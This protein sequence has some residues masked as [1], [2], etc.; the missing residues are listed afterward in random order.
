MLYD[1]WLKWCQIV[2]TALVTSGIAA[3]IFRSASII[4]ILTGLLSAIHLVITT[5]MKNKDYGQIAQLH[6][7][8]AIQ[9]WDI[10]ERLLSLLIDYKDN[11]VSV[12]EAQIKRDEIHNQLL[13]VYEKA[14][15]T[16][17]KAYSKAK[18]ALKDSEELYFSKDEI[19]LLL[20]KLL[21]E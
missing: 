5:Y 15:R 14:P 2:I 4:T 10:R 11:R 21:R 8:T 9:V 6:A 17:A 3:T 20:P 7:L 13:C 16:S 1:H 19:N 12:E 18:K